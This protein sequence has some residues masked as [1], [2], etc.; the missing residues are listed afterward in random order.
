[1]GAESLDR[2]SANHQVHL[3]NESME[4]LFR[5]IYCCMAYSAKCTQS[6]G[7]SLGGEP[8]LEGHAEGQSSEGASHKYAGILPV[9]KACDRSHCAPG[10]TRAGFVSMQFKI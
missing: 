4:T 3:G 1:M 9:Q 7:N 10:E 6:V 2:S 8:A 5:N